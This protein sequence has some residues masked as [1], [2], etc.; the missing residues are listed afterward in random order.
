MKKDSILPKNSPA[1]TFKE[2]AKNPLED[3]E[4]IKNIERQLKK[5]RGYVFKMPKP[6]TP[7]ILMFSGGLDS[8]TICD[9]LLRKY[10]LQVYP[11]HLRR[12]QIRMP[13]EEKAVADL[14]KYFS[15]EFPKLYHQPQIVNAFIPPLEFRFDVTAHAESKAN[16]KNKQWLGI[17]MYTSMAAEY[18][19]NYAIYLEKTKGIKIRNIFFGIMSKDGLVMKYETLTFLRSVTNHIC[20]LM[21]DYSW[22]VS[23]LPVEKELGYYF[24]KEPLIQWCAEYNLPIHKS[25]SCLDPHYFHCGSCYYCQRRKNIT[26]EIGVKDDTFYIDEQPFSKPTQIIDKILY[27][28]EYTKFFVKINK[29]F[30]KYFIKYFFGR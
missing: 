7:V 21:G 28:R 1:K 9:I 23:S 5:R 8:T 27:V 13:I 25:F 26:K 20:Q 29:T 6:G 12:G 16:K 2:I 18:A 19:V 14:S 24:D 30:F 15:K 17:P 3:I 10:G 22:Q 11:L 4:Y